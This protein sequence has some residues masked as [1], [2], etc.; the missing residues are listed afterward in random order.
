MISAS[1]TL[2][3]VQDTQNLLVPTITIYEVFRRVLQEMDAETA[4]QITG[5][6]SLGKAVVLD[7]EIGI[8]AAKISTDLKLSMADS[9]ILATARLFEA[10]LWTQ[11]AHF[12]GMEGV[13]YIEKET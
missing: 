4:L 9:I 11:D 6:M 5:V 12:E 10:T 2:L 8:E 7:R 13:Q 1:E 3:L